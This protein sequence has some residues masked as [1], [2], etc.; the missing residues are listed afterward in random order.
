M[1]NKGGAGVTIPA[2]VSDM[3]LKLFGIVAACLN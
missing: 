2:Q 3:C 1:Q